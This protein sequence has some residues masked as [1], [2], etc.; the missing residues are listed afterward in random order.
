MIADT[1]S[2]KT[3]S[4]VGKLAEACNAVGG[5]EKKG[6]N[7]K[8]NY[9]YIR[10]ADVA[11][12]IRHELFQRGVIL[13]AD[14]KEF[15]Q[16]GAVKTMSGG[17]M[18]EF[19]LKVEYTLYD[20]DSDAK[21]TTVAYGV[22]M[23]TGDKAIYKCKTG[24]VKY[25]LRSLGLIPDEKDDVEADE[26]VD[27]AVAPSRTVQVVR[28][29]PTPAPKPTPKKS[30]QKTDEPVQA[31]QPERGEAVTAQAEVSP[32]IPVQEQSSVNRT[33]T[34]EKLP[35]GNIHGLNI[36]D[37]DLPDNLR[38]I[39]AVAVPEVDQKPSK[40]E[41]A[42][43]KK[44]LDGYS[45]PL[46]EIGSFIKKKYGFSSSSDLTSKQWVEIFSTLDSAKG[47]T[48]ELKKILGGK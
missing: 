11:K 26:T 1:A 8:Q 6:T 27:E 7:Q 40:E 4:L 19:T 13:M 10:A 42:D 36:T 48:D 9:K 47:D 2:Q 24:A 45:V 23:D 15:T 12:S 39:P 16:T 43:I 34:G 41:K 28:T 21:I 38:A 22:A 17:E 14:E 32:N 44:R 35:S 46:T 37:D 30:V 5:I 31:N 3:L 29:A 18:R 33:A 20:S 25:Y